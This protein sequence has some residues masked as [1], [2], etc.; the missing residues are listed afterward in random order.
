[1]LS[2]DQCV[3]AGYMS[4]NFVAS[5]VII[6]ANKLAYNSGFPFAT[7]LTV[8]HFAAT[9]IGLEIAARYGLFEK[10][11][12]Q[13]ISVVP[14]S[15]AFCGFVVF[16]NLSLQMNAIGTYQLLKVMTTPTIVTIQYFWYK[17]SLPAIQIISLLPVCVGVV[18]ATVS[19]VDTNFN[20]TIFGLCGIV[21]TSI[22]QIWVKTEQTRLA[23]SSQQLLY[24]QAPLSSVLL[25]AFVPLV[26]DVDGLRALAWLTPVCVFWTVTSSLFA[27]LV[28]LSIFLVIERTSPVSYNVLGHGKLCVIIVSGYLFFGDAYTVKNLVGVCMAV[29]GIMWYTH[30][31]LQPQSETPKPQV[32]YEPITEEETD[33]LTAEE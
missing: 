13:L 16:N 5:V 21:S 6:W 32:K 15:V 31:K 19:S 3:T 1:M 33:A 2:G 23:C 7:T 14:I 4:L 20:G 26:E 22:Y 30:L 8:V 10:K 28:N 29:I 17:T 9:F 27:F 11:S 18:L 24:Y 25:L 12:I